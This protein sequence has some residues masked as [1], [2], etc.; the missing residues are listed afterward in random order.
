MRL[1]SVRVKML[2]QVGLSQGGCVQLDFFLNG[3]ILS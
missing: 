3:E 2:V 1:Y